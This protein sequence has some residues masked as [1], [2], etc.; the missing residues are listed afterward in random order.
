MG[1]GRW[2]REGGGE[3]DRGRQRGHTHPGLEPPLAAPCPSP[4]SPAAHPVSDSSV[5]ASST[6]GR[7]AG[8]TAGPAAEGVD[9]GTSRTLAPR[10]PAIAGIGG[11]DGPGSLVAGAACPRWPTPVHEPPFRLGPRLIPP[12]P[13]KRCA[14]SRPSPPPST[15]SLAYRF[16]ALRAIRCAPVLPRRQ[17]ARLAGLRGSA[18]Q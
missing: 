17:P 18:P 10:R 2:G 5:I 13:A 9:L 8:R 12:S 4:P 7:A 6:A 14:P 16:L 15:P 3:I 1:E 11:D